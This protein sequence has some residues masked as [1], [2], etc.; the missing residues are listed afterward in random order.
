VTRRRWREPTSSSGRSPDGVVT[1]A[2]FHV[3]VDTY[4]TPRFPNGLTVL[5]GAGQFRGADEL[6]IKEE[7]FV[8]ILIYPADS[9]EEC[10]RRIEKIRALY[11]VLH[12][13]ESV[14]RIDQPVFASRADPDATDCAIRKLTRTWGVVV[15]RLANVGRAASGPSGSRTAAVGGHALQVRE[16]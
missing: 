2:Q 12:D 11:K 1:E 16:D 6:I 14:L 8:L 4:V 10:S 15:R 13:Q 5:K 7:S 9:V 3:F